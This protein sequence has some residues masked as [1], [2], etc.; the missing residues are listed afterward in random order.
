MI[1]EGVIKS[2]V[3]TYELPKTVSDKIIRITQQRT[4]D[5]FIRDY[6]KIYENQ[7]NTESYK[8]Q[9]R[10][11]AQSFRKLDER[12]KEIRKNGRTRLNSRR[13]EVIKLCDDQLL[14]V[15][16]PNLFKD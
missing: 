13:Q 15:A 9:K 8:Y 7:W 1:Q 6:D 14:W 16:D 12:R 11:T 2:I 5:L 4:K 10:I 3:D